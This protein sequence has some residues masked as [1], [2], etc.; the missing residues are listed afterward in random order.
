MTTLDLYITNTE[1]IYPDRDDPFENA[2]V[3][4]YCRTPETNEAKTVTVTGQEPYFFILAA[5]RDRL[6]PADHEDIDR[7]EETDVVPLEDRFLPPAA[8]RD[9]VKVVADYPGGVRGLRKQYDIT[10]SA[11][12]SFT[13][14][15]RIDR[16][17]RSGIR[18]AIGDSSPDGTHFLVDSSK[19]LPT[20]IEDVT[21]RVCTLD[22]ETDDRGSGFPE[23]GEARVLSIAAHDSYSDE[24]V[25]FVDVDGRDMQEWFGLGEAPADLSDFGIE[26]ADRLET[27]DGE[28]DMFRKFAD[29]IEETNPDIMAGW[30]SGDENEDGFDFP[31]LFARMDEANISPA[32]LAREDRYDLD[33]YRGDWTT[34]LQ[35]RTTY[36]LMDAWASTKF[37]EPDSK[38]L[39]RVAQD[40]LDDAK[41]EH[42]DMG[43]YEMYDE[44]P[45]KFLSYNAKDTRLTADI[46]ERENVFG[47]KKRLK[48]MVGVDW[49]EVRQNRYFVDMSIRRKCSEHGVVMVTARDN[50]RRAAAS[51]SDDEVNYEGA[52]VLSAFKGVK[53]N[54]VGV[55]LASLYPMTQWMLNASPDTKVSLEWVQEADPTKYDW[56]R[57]ENGVYFRT[58]VD[59]IIRELV[60]EYDE[61]KMEYKRKRNA[62]VTGSKEHKELSEAYNVTKT[63]YNSY[64]GYTGWA[65]SPIYDPEIAAAVT[66]TGQR[67]IKRT[68]EWIGENTEGD[69][70]YGDTDSN[71]VQFPE[72]W[73][74]EGT[75]EYAE[76]ICETLTEEVYPDL[77][78]EFGID[79]ADNRWLIEMEMRA[80][81]F[82][83]H[84]KKKWYS[85]HKT[86]DE[87][88]PF[89]EVSD[90]FDVT[91]YHCVKSSTA[92]LTKEVQREVLETIVRG[93][94][95]EDVTELMFEAA[96][97]IDSSDP[98]W[99][100]LGMPQGLGK[101]ISQEKAYSDDY[102]N[103]SKTGDHP[104]DA[105]PRGA[106]FANH[107]LDVEFSK[108]SKPKRSYLKE[109]LTVEGEPVDVICYDYG[110]DLEAIADD[111]QMDVSKMQE[112]V[113]LN[114]MEKILDAFDMEPTAAIQGNTQSQAGLEAFL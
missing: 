109:T 104:Q 114:P 58:D 90:E 91:G 40:A 106:W 87:G 110:D 16:E 108:G 46:A 64:Y 4:L 31:H 26:G 85:Y 22:I 19:V 54:L 73:S 56:V 23:P 18:V 13:N 6:P 72:D 83:M 45:A 89:D 103:W 74:Q 95:K 59:S 76:G 67:V 99:D 5:E 61:L 52:H 75:L 24:M 77:C 105:H 42:P 57:A 97:S 60:D 69:V 71:Y 41:I 1:T 101:D 78:D 81:R 79:P 62:A 27:A 21:P 51:Q 37:T 8:Q 29:F 112:K 20:P 94:S 92:E 7:I 9:L 65:L 32:R 10:W 70:V 17:I 49:D 35:G 38:K 88:D 53:R 15:F 55:D 96:S 113:L 25:V 98:D 48:D 2:A 36:D 3:R 68:A 34:S 107:L 100:R 33:E 82:F 80:E 44:D 50:P 93:G 39:D 66:L 86:W 63:I 47:F 111:V 11:D 84:G 43:Y 14:Q 30:N 12:V 28:R 102:Y